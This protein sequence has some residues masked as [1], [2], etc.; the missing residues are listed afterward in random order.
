[1]NINERHLCLACMSELNNR[2]I[3]DGCGYVQIEYKPFPRC[4]I[5]GTKLSNRYVLGKVLGEGSFGITYIGWDTLLDLPVAIKEYYPSDLVSRDV[6]RS[7]D[8]SVYVYT[9][10]SQASYK[11]R[12]DKFLSEARSIARFNQLNAVVSVRDY[13]YENNT[14]YIVMDYVDGKRFKDEIKENGPMDANTVLEL[15]KPIFKSLAKIHETGIIH[16]DISPDNLMLTNDGNLVLIDFGSAELQNA[17][18]TRSITIMFKRG[19]SPEE[20]YRLKGKQGPWTDIYSMCASMYYGMTGIVPDESI[21]RTIDD[22]VK[23]L[24]EIKEIDIEESVAKAIMKGMSVVASNRFRS[25]NELYS[26]LYQNEYQMHSKNNNKKMLA[27]MII[28]I[29]ILVCGIIIQSQYKR[30]NGV[31]S[32]TE[33]IQEKTVEQVT[34]QMPKT[35]SEEK[36]LERR[37]IEQEKTTAATTQAE[38]RSEPTTSE[39]KK[40]DE[41]AV[42]STT[43]KVTTERNVKTTSKEQVDGFIE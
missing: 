7:A 1:M 28:V 25:V 22:K 23:S 38:A 21:Q 18:L 10:T 15:F 33:Q 42:P 4:L 29:G 34:E 36:K 11:E 30:K 17:E 27:I 35:T 13:F 12:L 24:V 41:K 8:K 31:A 6:L 32:G 26:A 3:C 19:F 39:A 9:D 40:E 2:D 43:K 37:Q 5:P 16:R 14:A 20:Q